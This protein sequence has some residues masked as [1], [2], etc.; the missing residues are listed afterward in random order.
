MS[1]TDCDQILEQIEVYLDLELDD[2]QRCDEIKRHLELC[3]PCMDRVEFRASLRL[4][5]SKKCSGE[6]MPAALQER[7]AAVVRGEGEGDIPGN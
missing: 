1:E 6:D 2:R 4:L 3:P 7:V 5:I